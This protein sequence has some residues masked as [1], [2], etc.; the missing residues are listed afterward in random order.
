MPLGDPLPKSQAFAAHQFITNTECGFHDS[1]IVEN[2]S[3]FRS[4]SFELGC[5]GNGYGNMGQLGHAQTLLP[6]DPRGSR[7]AFEAPQHCRY[8]DGLVGFRGGRNSERAGVRNC[9]QSGGTRSA[10]SNGGNRSGRSRSVQIKISTR[11][12]QLSEESQ[13]K[14]REKTER[15]VRYFERLTSIE[16]TVD[17]KSPDSPVVQLQVSAE[18]KHDFVAHGE[19]AE[20]S[21]AVDAA[22]HKMEEQ[23]R[24]YKERIQGH[25]RGNVAE[26]EI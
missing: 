18:H 24:R 2:F 22:V 23:L 26:P 20:L 4:L 11:H 15:L 3:D 25:H 5:C 7:F 10:R 17:L 8:N 14:V 21:K 9:R 12:G 16:V 1:S 6:L 13:Q 19:G